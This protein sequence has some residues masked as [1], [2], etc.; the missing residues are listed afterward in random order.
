MFRHKIYS[1]SI[2]LFKYVPPT[3][4]SWGEGDFS[5]KAL[6]EILVEWVSNMWRPWL[7]A[8][9]VAHYL[10]VVVFWPR[11]YLKNCHNN[12]R[13]IIQIS[14]LTVHKTGKKTGWW[15]LFYSISIIWIVERWFWRALC[16][17]YL[18]RV[19]KNLSSR[20]TRIYDPLI[21]RRLC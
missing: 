6:F 11:K 15:L 14:L 20:E 17:E 1:E 4:T 7:K 8:L 16:S 9:P 13:E 21:R 5:F 2:M 3:P 12:I 19:M 18:T 10:L